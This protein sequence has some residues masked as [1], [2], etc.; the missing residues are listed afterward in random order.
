MGSV[1]CA[2]DDSSQ[3]IKP[4]ELIEGTI[5]FSLFVFRIE[6]GRG[7]IFEN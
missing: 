4:T 5:Q 1:Q 6:C 7:S 2:L 3:S